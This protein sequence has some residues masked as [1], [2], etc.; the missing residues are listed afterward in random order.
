MKQY[1]EHD[2]IGISHALRKDDMYFRTFSGGYPYLKNGILVRSNSIAPIYSYGKNY[3][4]GESKFA[5]FVWT[6]NG[7]QKEIEKLFDLAL[8]KVTASHIAQVSSDGSF[9]YID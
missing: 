8:T 2:R 9:L 5:L 4:R 1:A 3:T 6:T 7:D